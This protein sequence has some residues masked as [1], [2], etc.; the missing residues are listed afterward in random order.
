MTWRLVRRPQR[1]SGPSFLGDV[2]RAGA[3]LD[4]VEP[5]APLQLRPD[6]GSNLWDA[7]FRVIAAACRDLERRAP[8]ARLELVE[9]VP[10]R[11]L[12][13]EDGEHVQVEHDVNLGRK[14]RPQALCDGELQKPFKAILSRRLDGGVRPEQRRVVRRKRQRRRTVAQPDR[15]V[16]VVQ[17]QRAVALA[18]LVAVGGGRLRVVGA[19]HACP[20]RRSLVPVPR[21][22]LRAEHLVLARAADVVVLPRA[23]PPDRGFGSEGGWSEIRGDVRSGV[24]GAVVGHRRGGAV[25]FRRGALRESKLS[26]EMQN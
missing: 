23:R 14:R 5:V 24:C 3:E 13:V 18:R 7:V 17:R 19:Q 15:P 21:R 4:G 20:L 11:R 9:G 8:P 2:K 26:P 16:A 12:R 22:R 1:G 6:H 25:V 10:Q